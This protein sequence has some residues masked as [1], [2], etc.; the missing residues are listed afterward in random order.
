MLDLQPGV[1]LEEGD[2]AVVSDEEFDCAGAAVGHPAGEG[3]RTV[4]ECPARGL[5]DPR[6]RGLLDDLLV[7]ALDGAVTFAEVDDISVGVAE[8][9]HLHVAAVFDQGFHE[10]T[11]VAEGCLRLPRRRGHDFRHLRGLCDDSHPAATATSSRL[12]HRRQRQTTDRAGAHRIRG[13]L[14]GLG[15]GHARFDCLGLGGQ[16]VPQQLDLFRRRADP[17]QPGG[18]DGSGELR[19]LGE[20]PVAGMDGVTTCGDGRLDHGVAPQVRLGRRVATEC[21]RPVHAPGVKRRP[22]GLGE[23]ADGPYP[24]VVRSTGDPHCD[25]PPIRY[26]QP[27]Q[28][29][30]S[31]S[32]TAAGWG[33]PPPRR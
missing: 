1:D 13:D 15:G 2:R 26:Q 20:E 24:H 3:H 14:D 6:R 33:T 31:S 16:L 29:H 18:F 27:C 12:D 8:Y 21:H 4:A 19:V 11:A 30:A 10:H 9:L 25:L 5:P 17:Q 7:A 22:V 23:H 28:H 32:A